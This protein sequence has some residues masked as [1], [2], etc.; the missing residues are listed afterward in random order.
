MKTLLS[1]FILLS[2]LFGSA[3]FLMPDEV[4]KPSAH[5]EQ[6][7]VVIDIKLAQ[8]IELYKQKI[9]V[10]L[11]DTDSLF[12]KEL[13]LPQATKT[14]H[15]Q[16]VY[17]NDVT[18][19]ALIGKKESALKNENFTVILSFQGCSNKGLCYE[20][21]FKKYP[22]SIDT[23][24]LGATKPVQQ[25][26]TD[27]ISSS[28]ENKSMLVVLATFFGFG[29]L[30]SMT[31]CIFPMIPILSSI[32]VSQKEGMTAKKG[33]MLSLV[34][35]LAMASAYTIAGVLA[36]L[37]GQNLQA[38]MQN[39]YVVSGFALIFVA[40]ALSMFGFY[41][42]G[43]PASL[44]SKISKASDS[45]SNKGGFIGVGIM[46]FLSALIVGPCVAPPL[47]GTLIYIGQ[48]G[49]ALF[50]GLAL[51]VMSLG[52]GMPLLLIGLGTGKFMPR[53]GEWMNTV[54]KIFGVFMLGIAIWILEKI[55]PANVTMALWATLFVI[56]A[57]YMGVFEPLGEKKSWNAFT[58][59][60]GVI[61]LVF[62]LS[63]FVGLFSGSTDMLHPFKNFTQGAT[64]QN[65]PSEKL[66][67]QVVSSINQLDSVLDQNKGKKIMLDFSAKWCTAC[68][69]YDEITFEDKQVIN[70]L[71]NNYVL[72]RADLTD[73]SDQTKAL[74]KKYGV[75]GPP[76]V[77]FVDEKSQVIQQ[78]KIIGYK[79][80][81]EFL[82]ILANGV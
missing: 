6:D 42:I 38:A 56:S 79:P 68:K 69:E 2:T 60:L 50:G 63:L 52:M 39:P 15:N 22:L 49:N 59:G 75:F 74:A 65:T 11:Q 58:K 36:G 28:F 25:T 70:T 51:F 5:L 23:T 34:Y 26:D 43:L 24:I 40:L 72:V 46:G 18:F 81:Q 55:A 73:N 64:S 20:P 10:K 31:P 67:F 62:G 48:T 19:S 27:M 61:S 32:I 14:S 16:E 78:Q 47:A 66:N 37:F 54:S 8:D 17:E 41:E 44:Q 30:L 4:F 45:A 7:K 9:K 13:V 29:L 3:D 35:V 1:L 12:I 77:I 21:I 57:I 53:P 76:A 82:S 71:K 80:P 33:F